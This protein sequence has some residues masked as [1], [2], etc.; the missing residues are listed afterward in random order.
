MRCVWVGVVL[1]SSQLE[2]EGVCEV[3]AGRGGAHLL[4]VGE[5]RDDFKSFGQL[6]RSVLA[7]NLTHTGRRE[8]AGEERDSRGGE[9]RSID[10][11]E[12]QSILVC[13]CVCVCNLQAV[14]L[15]TL[16]V[17][18]PIAQQG[19]TYWRPVLIPVFPMVC[20]KPKPVKPRRNK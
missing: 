9:E 15:R 20:R 7:Q 16:T 13:V 10:S 18:M 14:I 5:G 11:H 8:T 17:V 1:T 4:P 19:W 2:R 12:H 3:C 6:S